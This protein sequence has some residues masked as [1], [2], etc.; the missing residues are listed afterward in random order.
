MIVAEYDVLAD[1]GDAYAR[2]LAAAGVPV[3]H[4]RVNGLVHG[5]IRWHNLCEPAREQVELLARD[6]AEHSARAE[7]P[8]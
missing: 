8:A 7:A 1:E 4:R 6:I 2:E 5:F 3:T